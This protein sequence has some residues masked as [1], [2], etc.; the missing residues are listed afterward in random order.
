MDSLS[1]HYSS[2]SLPTPLLNARQWQG[3]PYDMPSV[4]ISPF[5]S[6][7]RPL[8]DAHFQ[9]GVDD[10][11]F[12]SYPSSLP[13]RLSGSSYN[14][15]NVF[16]TV[17]VIKD[18]SGEDQNKMKSIVDELNSF[19]VVFVIT[20]DEARKNNGNTLHLYKNCVQKVSS[21]LKHEQIRCSYISKEVQEMVNA[22]E[23]WLWKVC[24]VQK[25]QL[26]PDHA[27]LTD[28]ILNAS[29]LAHEIREIYH[30]LAD[31]AQV[32]VCINRW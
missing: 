15:S 24:N 2:P 27:Q 30:G 13:K 8:F 31:A 29:P 5:L 23:M 1:D 26:P 6:P 14:H 7:K 19:L 12:L 20:S 28:S 9:V 16:Q 10:M 32:N 3:T 25:G 21:A 18:S 4:V 17:S 22:R 11:E